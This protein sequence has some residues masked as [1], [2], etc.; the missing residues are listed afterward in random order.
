[1]TKFYL[2]ILLSFLICG[3]NSTLRQKNVEAQEHVGKE[4]W[5]KTNLH[6]FQKQYLYWQNYLSGELLPVGTA[7]R[8]KEVYEDEAILTDN[9]NND[10]VLYWKNEDSTKFQQIFDRYFLLEDPASILQKLKPEVLQSISLAELKRGMTKQETLISLG[11]PPS[12]EDP[13]KKDI[14][15]YWESETGKRAVYFED[16][17]VTNIVYGE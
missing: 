2:L 6:L 5:T 13:Y 1:M 4:L 7:F 8:L 3:C 11:Y 15:I 10:Y 9:E 12:L 17:K 14:W 16:N